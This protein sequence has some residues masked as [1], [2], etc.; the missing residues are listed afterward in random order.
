[1]LPDGDTDP[2][3]GGLALVVRVNMDAGV[4]DGPGVGVEET[5]SAKLPVTAWVAFMVT[6]Q[7]PL[8]EQSPDQS[9][10]LYPPDGLWVTVTCV[11]AA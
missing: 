9:A 6:T 7:E 8:P 5:I 3:T 4:G 2:P 1:L 10:K 11:P